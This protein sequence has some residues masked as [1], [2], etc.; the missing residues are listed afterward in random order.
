MQGILAAVTMYKTSLIYFVRTKSLITLS[1]KKKVGKEIQ[2]VEF[3][4]FY[5]K[6]FSEIFQ[7]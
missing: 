3:V 1:L 2:P 4:S 6:S 5:Y 7:N